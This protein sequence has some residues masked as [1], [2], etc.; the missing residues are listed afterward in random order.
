MPNPSPSIYSQW[1][2]RS[3]AATLATA[4]RKKSRRALSI[5]VYFTPKRIFMPKSTRR[6]PSRFSAKCCAGAATSA[7]SSQY[8]NYQLINRSI[9]SAGFVSFI[10]V[11]CGVVALVSL[12]RSPLAV[13]NRRA[14]AT[15]AAA[16]SAVPQRRGGLIRHL[17]PH[18]P[19]PFARHRHRRRS[20]IRPPPL[21]LDVRQSSASILLLAT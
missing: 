8:S 16:P 4:I 7:E 3:Y 13:L 14:A 17:L 9:Q 20:P 10:L 2:V 15:A 1:D 21:S 12:R 19:S 6:R 18:S 11:R 5:A